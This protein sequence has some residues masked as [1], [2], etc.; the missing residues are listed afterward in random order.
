[1]TRALLIAGAAALL[2]GAAA[3][4]DGASLFRDR[5]GNCHSVSE[6]DSTPEGP[7]LKGVYGRAKASLGDFDYSA[8]LK[9]KGGKW[10]DADLDAFI[11]NPRSFA[12]GS[13][14]RTV[15]SDAATRTAL[16]AYLKSQGGR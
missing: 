14:M 5:C 7:S 11:A 12:P 9:A 2:A 10:T 13:S 6:A 8:A 3:A 4:Q 1:M 15:V 16:I